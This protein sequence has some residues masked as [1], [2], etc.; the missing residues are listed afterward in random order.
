MT[1]APVFRKVEDVLDAVLPCFDCQN[2]VPA[3]LL[4]GAWGL[5]ASCAESPEQERRCPD[6]HGFG[7]L[8]RLRCE[9]SPGA[10]CPCPADE[11]R[12]ATCAGRGLT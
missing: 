6:C 7:R 9:H 4:T 11:V 8:L 12:C 1:P 3:E 5:C 2:L 10:V